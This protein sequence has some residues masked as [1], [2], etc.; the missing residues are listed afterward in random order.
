MSEVATPVLNAL[1]A[2]ER[3]AFAYVRD[4]G[5]HGQRCAV[6]LNHMADCTCGLSTLQ[7]A[8]AKCSVAR[9]EARR[10]AADHA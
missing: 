6:V 8:L 9:Q 7:R 3:A 10:D 1:L 2:V 5:R 4:A